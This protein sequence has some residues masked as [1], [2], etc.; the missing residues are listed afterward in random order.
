[1]RSTK[2]S[3]ANDLLLFRGKIYVP[4]DHKL[5]RHIVAQHHDTKVTGHPGCFKTL[6]LVTCN[7]WWPQ[8]S[9]FISKY[10]K[11]CNLCN[12]TKPACHTPIGKLNP[13]VTP[14]EC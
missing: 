1:M 9:H 6:E 12:Q 5:H 14:E 4:K 2:W 13:S 11:H 7:Y 3:E 8:M 10:V